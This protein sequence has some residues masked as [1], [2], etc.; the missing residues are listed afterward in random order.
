[1]FSEA[2]FAKANKILNAI[3]RW[4]WLYECFAEITLVAEIFMNVL[5]TL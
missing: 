3:N 1:M 2:E 4:T 5:E